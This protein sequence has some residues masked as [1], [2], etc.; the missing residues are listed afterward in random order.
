M[1]LI[2]SQKNLRRVSLRKVIIFCLLA[3]L[4]STGIFLSRLIIPHKVRSALNL[5]NV[6]VSLGNSRLSYYAGVTSGAQYASHITIDASGNP[7][8]DTHHLFP[9]DNVCFAPSTLVGCRDDEFDIKADLQTALTASDLA[10]AT[11]S[12]SMT[13]T[14]T[15]TSEIPNGGAILI[16]LPMSD[17][18]DGNDSWPDYNTN[19]STAT[20]NVNGFD[21]N[22]IAAADI[23]VN[24]CTWNATETITEG[25]GTTDHTILIA[26]TD[27]CAASTTL[28]VT[29][30]SSPGIINPAPKTTSH[31]QG[32]ADIYAINIKTLAAS[33]DTSSVLDQT[34]V[35]VAP[36][37]AVL[38]SATVDETLFFS[39]T[40]ITADSGTTGTCG[41]T[42]TSNSPDSTAYSIPWGTLVST[43]AEAKNNTSQLL[44]V[45]TN[46]DAGYLVTVVANDQM[47]KSGNTCTGDAGESVSCI[48]D[49]ACG[50]T[51]CTHETAQDW[52]ADPS[53]YPGLGYS[54]EEVTSGEASFEFD[55]TGTFFAKQFADEQDSQ[56]AQTIMTNANPVADSQVY[57]CFRIDVTATQP[58]G[59]YFNKIRY[60]A[61]A[62]F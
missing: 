15:T 26:A 16:T 30:D 36:I 4:T 56:I 18:A 22:G 40:G 47:G 61:T 24:T 49:T 45:D 42:R 2:M 62:R 8:N 46:A 39:V 59:Y 13:F 14:F 34:D 33:G 1:E 58:S 29:V 31:T 17:N 60:T 7:D 3:V 37:E 53:S 25:S 9:N 38:V 55:D 57:I 28:I 32:T 48:P 23:S 54:L 11:Q 6:S 12:G 50:L 20:S 44:E 27:A 43:Y 21:L 35:R 5:T 19:D 10:I 51:P 52:G 41:I